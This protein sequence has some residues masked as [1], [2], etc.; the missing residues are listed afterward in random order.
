MKSGLYAWAGASA[1]ASAAACAKRFDEPITKLSN[2]YFGFVPAGSSFTAG[3]AATSGSVGS[4]SS[5]TRSAILTSRPSTS[6]VAARSKPRKWLS[7][8]S[9][10]KSLGT[11]TRNASSLSEPPLAAWNHVA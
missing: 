3:A 6:R 1:T 10:V 9:R 7:I 8:H 2:V 4:G 5:A 11:T